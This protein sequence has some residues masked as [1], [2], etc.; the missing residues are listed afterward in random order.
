LKCGTDNYPEDLN[1][2]SSEEEGVIA[3]MF[4]PECNASKFAKTPPERVQQ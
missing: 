4:C 3:D 1:E 2:V